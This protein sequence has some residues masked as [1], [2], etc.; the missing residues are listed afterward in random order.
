MEETQFTQII[1]GYVIQ[2]FDKD[3]F[4]LR[5]DFIESEQTEW[6]NNNQEP[7][8]EPQE[9]ED[10]PRDLIQPDDEYDLTEVDDDWPIEP[11][12]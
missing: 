1:I 5:Q 4:L 10:F 9:Y 3:G 2:S 12:Y 6:E 7:I 8:D 11:P